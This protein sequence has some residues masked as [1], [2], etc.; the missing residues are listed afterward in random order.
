MNRMVPFLWLACHSLLCL[1]PSRGVLCLYCTHKIAFD[2]KQKRKSRSEERL[3]C[4]RLQLAAALKRQHHPA[5]TVLCITSA[6]A[7]ASSSGF[8][9]V[10]PDRLGCFFFLI[11]LLFPFWP[12]RRLSLTPASRWCKKKLV[13][14]YKH[15]PQESCKFQEVYTFLVDTCLVAKSWVFFFVSSM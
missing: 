9:H 2:C 4:R 12:S 1:E 6:A 13:D 5:V 14:V 3:D 7:A 10:R 8:R 15:I 11:L